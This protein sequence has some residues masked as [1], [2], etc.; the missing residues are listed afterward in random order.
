MT[1]QSVAKFSAIYML[2][3]VLAGTAAAVWPSGNTGSDGIS[4]A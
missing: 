1:M 3:A 2:F 4:T